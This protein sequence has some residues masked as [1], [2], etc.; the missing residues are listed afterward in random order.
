MYSFHA[1]IAGVYLIFVGEYNREIHAMCQT[2]R[3]LRTKQLILVTLI[4][5]IE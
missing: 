3:G 1:T 4:I 2:M 5:A